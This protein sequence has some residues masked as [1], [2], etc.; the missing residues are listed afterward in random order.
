MR[1]WEF[2][3]E[4]AKS[5]TQD[6]IADLKKLF[7]DGTPNSDIAKLLDITPTELKKAL[8]LYYPDRVKKRV[9]RSD[10]DVEQLKQL[11][12]QGK[13]H[14]EIADIMGL[15]SNVVMSLVKSRYKDRARKFTPVKMTPERLQDIK[16]AYDLGYSLKEMGQ[17]F[18]TSGAQI[19]NILTKYYPERKPRLVHVAKAATQEDK[20]AAFELWNNGI[21]IRGIAKK[22]GV[23][24]D[25][26]KNWLADQYGQDAVDQEQER[27]KTIGGSSL[28]MPNKVTPEMKEKMRKLYVTGMILRDIADALDNVVDPRTVLA[29]MSREPDFEELK[30][31]RDERK[32]KVKMKM[33]ATATIYRP[34]TI[35]NRRS[36]GPQ[37]RHTWGVS[38][39]KY[40]E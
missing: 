14:K 5:L 6:Q 20:A 33:D 21:G 34:G 40:G 28:R 19:G 1:A 30:A 26:I 10:V 17:L 36:K 3:T 8:T 37:N 25:A 4:G 31:I 13:T 39:P 9:P 16:D 7:D 32:Q 12:D 27:R 22:I 29:A 2:I 24:A 18:N 23:D 38:W 11:V 35:G 15:P